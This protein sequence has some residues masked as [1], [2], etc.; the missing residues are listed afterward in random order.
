MNETVFNKIFLSH[1]IFL[2]IQ[3]IEFSSNKSFK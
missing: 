3:K 2:I 1:K